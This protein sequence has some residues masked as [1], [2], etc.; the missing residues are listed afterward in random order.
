MANKCCVYGIC[1]CVLFLAG[2]IMLIT[3]FV[4]VDW[5]EYAFKK[6][7]ITNTVDQSQV[8]DVGRYVWGF[9]HTKVSFP[10]LFQLVELSLDVS[11]SEGVSV[12]IDVSFCYKLP[13][14][15]L[16]DI[17]SKY[18]LNYHNQ[19]TSYARAAVRNTAG[20]FSVNDFLAKRGEIATALA[21]NISNLLAIEVFVEVPEYTVQLNNVGFSDS[22]IT[23]HLSA[24]INLEKNEQK[25][26]EQQAQLIV[27]ET[28]KLVQEYDKNTTIIL[29]TAEASK[30]A[31]IKGAQAKYEEIIGQARGMGIATTMRTLQMDIANESVAN[32]FL[33]LMSILDNN[34]TQIINIGSSPVVNLNR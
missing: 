33:R 14:D 15:N 21:R 13:K 19:I 10:A 17:Y 27:T 34:Q 24:A 29:R 22:I 20:S 2:L 7:T 25:E 30:S 11:N 6:S 12:E 18:G 23:T 9:E 28:E 26:Y 3:S 8:Y 31:R 1:G 32:T 16:S 5:D 4:A